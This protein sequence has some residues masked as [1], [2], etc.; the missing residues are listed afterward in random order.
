[1]CERVFVCVKRGRVKEEKEEREREEKKKQ[2][3]IKKEKV[4]LAL[5]IIDH[6]YRTGF[7]PSKSENREYQN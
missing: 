5:D 7:V 3:R 4:Q 2:L 6:E 1:M